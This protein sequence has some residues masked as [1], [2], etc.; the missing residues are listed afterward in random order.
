MK[1]LLNAMALGLALVVG[2]GAEAGSIPTNRV[3]LQTYAI[4]HVD[5]Y[6]QPNGTQKGYIDPGDYVI[7]TQIRSDGW[8]YGSYPVGRGRTRRW[9][10]ANDLVSNVGFANQDRYSPKAN[11]TVYRNPNY[12]QS[13]GS[14]NNNEAIVVV[15]DSGQSRQVIYK[16]SNGNG[17]KMGWVPYWDCWSAEQAGKSSG[18]V[19]GAQSGI[20][21]AQSGN[22]EN[23]VKNKISYMKDN[24]NGF[25]NG[26]SYSNYKTR[27]RGFA[28]DVYTRL[29]SGVTRLAGY[30]ENHQ[31]ST[32]NGSYIVGEVRGLQEHDTSKVEKFFSNVKPGYYLQ[33]A[34]R[35]GIPHSAIV[36]YRTQDGLW[37]YD[38]NSD[39]KNTIK[40]HFKNWASIAKTDK[41]ITIYAP[42]NYTLK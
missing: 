15:S 30:K 42:N 16:L 31:A 5:C 19:Q 27:C 18:L 29:F 20:N 40:Y 10:R 2:V 33:I 23:N 28:N 36:V 17:Y 35:S 37:I 34:K 11:T 12:S 1:K 39:N 13:M 38:A 26:T 41:A 32:F 4:K 21:L 14:F 8:A 24:V 7:V 6:L 3:P 22:V 9:F 25:K